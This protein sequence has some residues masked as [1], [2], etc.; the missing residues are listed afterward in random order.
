MRRICLVWCAMLYCAFSAFDINE[1]SLFKCEPIFSPMSIF[2]FDDGTFWLCPVSLI[3]SSSFTSFNS[4]LFTACF[5]VDFGVLGVD[6]VE[7]WEPLLI[8]KIVPRLPHTVYI[9]KIFQ[10]NNKKN[11]FKKKQQ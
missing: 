4:S 7:D 5:G 11:Q 6:D 1:S 8:F 2:L 9:N 3:S 10:I